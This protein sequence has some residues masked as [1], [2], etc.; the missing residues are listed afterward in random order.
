MTTGKGLFTQCPVT[1]FFTIGDPSARVS[2]LRVSA[3]DVLL[4]EEL[5]DPAEVAFLGRVEQSGVAAQKVH[6]IL[7]KY[8]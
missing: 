6:H 1:R 2:N 3:V 4:R 7:K 8:R 5:L